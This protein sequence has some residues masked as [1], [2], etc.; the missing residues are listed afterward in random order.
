[1]SRNALSYD[2]FVNDPPLRTAFCPKGWNSDG[3]CKTQVIH[4]DLPCAP[5]RRNAG[6]HDGQVGFCEPGAPGRQHRNGVPFLAP[7]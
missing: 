7:S 2:V 3:A 4:E 5:I 1:M 6:Q